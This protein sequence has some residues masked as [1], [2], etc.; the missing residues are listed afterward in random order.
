MPAVQS[1]LSLPR[2]FDT[3]HRTRIGRVSAALSTPR[4]PL[5]PRVFNAI[6]RNVPLPI[7]SGRPPILFCAAANQV[8][9]R[10][11]FLGTRLFLFAARP[12]GFF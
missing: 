10:V 9:R 2:L 7:M 3:G 4:F 5:S 6:V 8:S 11:H 12:F 1:A